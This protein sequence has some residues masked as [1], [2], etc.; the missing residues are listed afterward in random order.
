[1]QQS[2]EEMTNAD[3]ATYSETFSELD[4]QRLQESTE[5]AEETSESLTSTDLD[6]QALDGY[7]I[8][9]CTL[10]PSLFDFLKPFI[11]YKIF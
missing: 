5:R 1:M 4:Q 6:E 7:F 10:L 8:Y 11:L 2:T 3:E 9:I